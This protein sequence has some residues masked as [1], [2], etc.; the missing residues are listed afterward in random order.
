MLTVRGRV[1]ADLD[2]LK[3]K[4]LPAMGPIEADVGT[5]YK[6]RAVAPAAQVAAAMCAA[7]GPGLDLRPHLPPAADQDGLEGADLVERLIV[8]EGVGRRPVG[9][10]DPEERAD[11]PPRPSSNGTPR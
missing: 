9:D 3:A 8:G 1:Q 2:A 5:D 7:I 11:E 4:Y 10:V 6:Y